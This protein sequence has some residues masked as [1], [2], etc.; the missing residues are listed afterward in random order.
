MKETL[1]SNSIFD[2]IHYKWCRSV[3]WKLFQVICNTIRLEPSYSNVTK[4][5]IMF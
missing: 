1:L 3:C 5:L 4:H 2:H